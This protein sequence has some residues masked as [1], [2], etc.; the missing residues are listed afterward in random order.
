MKDLITSV[1]AVF[2]VGRTSGAAKQSTTV[3]GKVMQGLRSRALSL[4]CEDIGLNRVSFPKDI[5]GLL[6]ETGYENGAST[7]IVLGD[8]TASLYFSGGGGVIGAGEHGAVRKASANLL[9]AANHFSAAASP[10]EAFPL[11]ARGKVTFYFLS[12]R[13]VLSYSAQEIAL[14]EGRDELSRLFYAGHEVIA[15]MREVEQVE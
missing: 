5:W 10:A 9:A 12:G 7:L 1:L 3:G 4:K 13:G 6:L 11:P 8:G 14:A 15:R 2:G